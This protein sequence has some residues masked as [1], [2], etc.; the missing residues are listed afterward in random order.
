MTT[1]APALT[2]AEFLAWKT[3]KEQKKKEAE[4][5]AQEQREADIAAGTAALTGREL[6]ERHP[7]LFEDY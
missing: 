1:P 6:Y 4:K 2:P 5:T 7:E 3:A